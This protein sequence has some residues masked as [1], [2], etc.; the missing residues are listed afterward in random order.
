MAISDR[1]A[2]MNQGR[3]VQIGTAEELYFRPRTEFVA[4]FIGKINTLPGHVKETGADGFTLDI[5]G[6]SY[7]LT[8]PAPLTS[9]GAELKVYV[10]PEMIELTSELSAAHF[11]ACIVDRTFL[12]EKVEYGLEAFGCSLWA[13]APTSAQQ[14]T[15]AVQQNV[16]MR[17]SADHLL[18]LEQESIP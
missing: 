17:L 5:W 7:R 10:R 8:C 13:T 1:I 9:A 6:H 12:G 14:E 4:K 16:G 15:F 2:V 3:I 18:L 11:Q